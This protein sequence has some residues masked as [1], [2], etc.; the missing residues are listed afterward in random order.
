MSDASSGAGSQILADDPEQLAITIINKEEDA[1]NS[2]RAIMKEIKNNIEKY[3]SPEI[4]FRNR[5][6]NVVIGRN[7]FLGNF[8]SS[9]S[10][11]VPGYSE[12]FLPNNQN[13]LAIVT[14]LV[15]TRDGNW[16]NNIFTMYKENADHWV[17]RV[18]Y[19]LPCPAPAAEHSTSVTRPHS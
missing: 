10:G 9:A 8:G 19:N 2:D 13:N 18:W 12:S 1:A 5:G 11:R 4:I 7:I 17:I 16:T 3:I 14:L 6:G 15:K